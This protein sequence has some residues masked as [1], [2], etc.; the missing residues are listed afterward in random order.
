MRCGF[1][2]KTREFEICTQAK[3]ILRCTTAC[4]APFSAKPGHIALSSRLKWIED[5]APR[6]IR[7]RGLLKNDCLHY[8]EA[9]GFGT[10]FIVANDGRNS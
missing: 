4:S 2:A 6:W 5:R 1:A 10:I 3:Q 8:T 9:A 7:M